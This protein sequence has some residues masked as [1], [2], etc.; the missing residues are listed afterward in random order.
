MCAILAF[1]LPSISL[2]VLQD[3]VSEEY[4]KGT[5]DGLKAGD[6]LRSLATLGN[7]ECVK[8]GTEAVIEADADAV[9]QML[10]GSTGVSSGGR[11]RHEWRRKIA[12]VSL[13][14]PCLR[15]F[16]LPFMDLPLLVPHNYQ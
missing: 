15:R 8:A 9:V 2:P 12:T 5:V 14:R 1:E 4:K 11:V 7:T 16:H 10:T 13:F 3:D 6:I